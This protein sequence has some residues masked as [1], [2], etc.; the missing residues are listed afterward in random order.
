MHVLSVGIRYKTQ[1][2]GI[3]KQVLF[4]TKSIYKTLKQYFSKAYSSHL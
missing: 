1:A 2:L 3:A 4:N